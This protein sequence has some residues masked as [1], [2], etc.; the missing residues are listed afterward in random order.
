MLK[1]E[2]TILVDN[3]QNLSFAMFRSK[4]LSPAAKGALHVWLKMP[5][6]KAA[7]EAHTLNSLMQARLIAER[8][9]S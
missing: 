2:E 4:E 6:H 7:A 5:A 8:Q 1:K 9:G 3:W